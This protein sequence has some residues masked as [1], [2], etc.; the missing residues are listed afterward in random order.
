MKKGWRGRL[1]VF[2]SLMI[3]LV[4]EACEGFETPHESLPDKSVVPT[5]SAVDE[6]L[7]VRIS[8]VQVRKKEAIEFFGET[9]LSVE[10]CL[11]SKL[12][13]ENKPLNWWPVGKCFPVSS[14]NWRFSVPLGVEDAPEELV[15]K[16]Q[17]RLSVYWPGAPDNVM[18]ELPFDVSPPPIP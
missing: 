4:L 2:C 9:N 18:A 10:N 11:Y 13:A 1:L 16:V 6:D 5:N 17:Y 12:Y 7:W 15:P 8:G 3:F 14:E